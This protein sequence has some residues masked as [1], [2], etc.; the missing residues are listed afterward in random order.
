ML[1]FRGTRLVRLMPL[2]FPSSAAD[3]LSAG[4]Q[5]QSRLRQI[6]AETPLRDYGWF[7]YESLSAMPV[8]TELIS[9]VYEE[10]AAAVVSKPVADL[11]CAD[12]DLTM[13]LA[14]FDIEVDAIDHRETNYNQMRGVEALQ[15]ALQGRVHLYDLDLDGRFSLPRQD[16]GLILFL[17]TLY[18]LKNPF[19]ALEALAALS[20]WCLVSTRIAQVA[21]RTR[22]RI[23]TEPLAYLLGSRE[24]NNDSTNFWIFSPGGLVRLLERA[25]WMV[26]TSKRVG[27]SVDSDPVRAD[28]DERMFLLAKSRQRHSELSV[29][30]LYGWYDTEEGQWRWVAKRFGL[31][32]ILHPG[33]SATEFALRF[34]APAALLAS[35]QPLRLSCEVNSIASG[36]VSC[37]GPETLEFRGRFP[38]QSSES[39][40]FI[41]NFSVESDYVPPSGDLRDLGV[42]IPLV[43]SSNRRTNRIPFRIS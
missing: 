2:E 24:A 25:G 1:R 8:L 40:V 30:P 23:E 31:E 34:T 38:P 22:V 28:A 35:G 29:R 27:C 21:P 4:Q 26:I 12:G 32:V 3:L 39:G 37:Y 19:Y 14:Q 17:G 20:D 33:E 11:G 43:E 6:K 13:L 41:L 15:K 7:P 10:I 16:Y 18:H 42:I 5:F 9:P 36:S